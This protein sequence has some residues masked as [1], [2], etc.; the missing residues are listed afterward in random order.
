MF[1]KK[2]KTAATN[3]GS[4]LI[5]LIFLASHH[6]YLSHFA[7]EKMPSPKIWN[8]FKIAHHN[9]KMTISR[10]PRAVVAPLQTLTTPQQPPPHLAINMFHFK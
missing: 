3:P 2:F 9:L 5:S 1:H 4:K 10:N 6:L 7:M 8:T